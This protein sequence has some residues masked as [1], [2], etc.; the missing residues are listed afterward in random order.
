MTASL[1]QGLVGAWCPSLGASGYRLVDR[2]GYGNHLPLIGMSTDN[3]VSETN[4]I[5]L[6]TTTGQYA[7]GERNTIGN[8]NGE[9]TALAWMKPVGT[10]AVDYSP[11]SKFEDVLSGQWMIWIDGGKV[12]AYWGGTR[13]TGVTTVSTAGVWQ[14][15]AISFNDGNAQSWYNGKLDASAS[16]IA[17]NTTGTGRIMIGSYATS[18]DRALRGSVGECLI[19]NRALTEAEH[20]RL[21]SGGRQLLKQLFQQTKKSTYYQFPSGSKRRRLLTG[22]P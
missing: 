8:F 15:V 21:Y 6:T 20:F 7:L 18:L 9:F 4:G 11:L 10:Q 12:K 5:S 14:L 17:P 13:A 22:M 3:W 2:S 16:S 19:Y 1:R